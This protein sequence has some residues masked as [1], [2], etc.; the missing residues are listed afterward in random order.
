MTQLFLVCSSSFRC[1]SGFLSLLAPRYPWWCSLFSQQISSLTT[2]MLL[3]STNMSIMKPPSPLNLK[4]IKMHLQQHSLVLK[5]ETINDEWSQPV[6][7]ISQN[8]ILLEEGY[9]CD[10]EAARGWRNQSRGSSTA[11][12]IFLSQ[13]VSHRKMMLFGDPT[14]SKPWSVGAYSDAQRAARSTAG[15][16]SWAGVLQRAGKEKRVGCAWVWSISHRSCACVS[17]QCSEPQKLHW[18]SR[19]TAPVQSRIWGEGLYGCR[20]EH[21]PCESSH[22]EDVKQK[23]EGKGKS[24]LWG[25]LAKKTVKRRQV[26]WEK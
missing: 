19:K 4:Q 26:V 3:F 7:S 12:P 16:S 9:F 20:A 13:Q 1:V 17:S 14:G 25:S 23:E 15:L 5:E 21:Q 24:T 10:W 22:R 8:E 18:G 2:G 6:V 11:V